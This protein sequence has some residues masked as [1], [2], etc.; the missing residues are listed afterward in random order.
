MH[1]RYLLAVTAPNARQ[2][3]TLAVM[4]ENAGLELVS[5]GAPYEAAAWLERNEPHAV[6]L[7]L[8][9]AGV[10][11]ICREVR[12][13]RQ[14]CGV[15]IIA[16][17][18]QIADGEA[19]RFYAVGVDDVLPLDANA[20][21][22]ARLRQVSQQSLAPPP[23]QGIAIVA[24]PEAHRGDIFGRVFMN[25]GYDI[26]YALDD[27]SLILADVASKAQVIVVSSK[28]GDPRSLI[29]TARADGS[30]A[31]WVVVVPRRELE[32]LG[33]RLAGLEGVAVIAR[34][35]PPTDSLFFANELRLPPGARQR[36]G[37]RRLYGTQVR[38]R[39]VG[40]VDTDFGFSYN[41]SDAGMYVRTLAPPAAARVWLE[42]RPPH[43]SE[44]A[45]LEAE[46]AWRRPFNTESAAAAVPP[47]FGVKLLS[48]LGQSLVAWKRAVRDLSRS[49]PQRAGGG[50]ATLMN[51]ALIGEAVP[52]LVED[53]VVEV[54]P[55]W[56]AEED[57]ATTLDGLVAAKESWEPVTED[58]QLI[59]SVRPPPA[60]AL[61][62]ELPLPPPP[63]RAPPDRLPNGPASPP[64]LPPV[65]VLATTPE[66]APDAD[67]LASLPETPRVM[68]VP[69][70]GK[71]RRARWALA[72]IGAGG[73]LLA[74]S[75]WALA[76]S[77]VAA[78]AAPA[79]ATPAVP[80]PVSRPAPKAPAA[81]APVE[82]APPTAPTPPAPPGSAP[83]SAEEM[84]RAEAVPAL[85]KAAVPT[86]DSDLKP[87][88]GG[89]LV[90]SQA[91]LRVFVQGVERGRTNERFVL[92]CGYRFL[93][94]QG[95]AEGVWVSEG[96]SV[97]V[98][99]KTT[100]EVELAAQPAE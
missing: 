62:A 56:G 45:C 93:R 83:A 33:Q 92:P 91:G 35:A 98:T 25:A 18:R 29:E 41:V 31:V 67:M 51:E 47:G 32:A 44:W 77:D 10:N 69:L 28:L 37:E 5:F 53:S 76:G 75:V 38:F 8:R 52:P 46:V 34:D 80:P 9:V 19:A 1:V 23:H 63:R 68:L 78:E 48:G 99:C 12:S 43:S 96:R 79:E 74:G 7:D 84:P 39:A 6:V 65:P 27:R 82:A 40:G 85:T 97:L 86:D 58:D 3:K 4:A 42:V 22:L 14:L 94:L 24:D 55:A 87:N 95:A 13:K 81:P 21:L 49:T 64:A 70:A 90:H 59:A 72:A 57:E 17:T 50:L 54:A 89:L 60:A 36:K 16:L 11:D 66:A 20:Q 61:P 73:L 30:A 71:P 26:K 100:T 88:E 15:P 2:A